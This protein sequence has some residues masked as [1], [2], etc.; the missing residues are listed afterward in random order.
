MDSMVLAAVLFG[1]LL[2]ASWNAML[3]ARGATVHAAASVTGGAALIGAV[4]L[5]FLPAPDAA[6]WPF[7]AASSLLQVLYFALLAA[8]YRGADISHVY[9]LIRGCAPV[10]VALCT[11][12]G[13]GEILRD[14]QWLAI[15][16]VC[17]GGAA[18]YAGSRGSAG[19][20][21]AV[22]LAMATAVV[23]AAYTVVDGVG[24]R[25]SGAPAAYTAWLFMVTGGANLLLAWRRLG[26]A[27][28]RYLADHPGFALAG[29][30]ANTASYGVALW[31]MTHAPVA[32]VA[33]LRETSIVFAVAIA[34]LVLRERVGPGRVA[35]A[36]LIV[37][38]A[39]ALKLA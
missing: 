1:A 16:L 25:R 18:V 7:I 8:T 12:L 37:G 30:V 21:R 19:N 36:L 35:G 5:P 27:L 15:G 10:L 22:L 3:K 2:H 31:A 28:P 29:G 4:L 24:V 33:A 34:V 26:A 39:A 11:G 9:P 17:A 20:G 13:G 32:V 6:S 14:G 38:G 23:I